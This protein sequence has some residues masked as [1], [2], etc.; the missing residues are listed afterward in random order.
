MAIF[1]TCFWQ[2]IR[3]SCAQPTGPLS[4]GWKPHLQLQLTFFL[5]IPTS[6]EIRSEIH[7]QSS[8]HA[9]TFKCYIQL[10]HCHQMTSCS[11]MRQR[12]SLVRSHVDLTHV[13]AQNTYGAHVA[14]PHN[15]SLN[16]WGSRKYAKERKFCYMCDYPSL[17]LPLI[18]LHFV[19]WFLL[20]R[21]PSAGQQKLGQ[22]D[23][24]EEVDH[25]SG[26]L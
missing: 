12:G 23:G 3:A 19:S 13:C 1:L 24:L 10:C 6:R 17:S 4:I 5:S 22:G 14:S 11:K 2:S 25:C 15:L 9:L 16:V 21:A 20:C 18:R 7:S 26:V 8:G